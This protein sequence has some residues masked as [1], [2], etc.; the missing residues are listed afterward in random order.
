MVTAGTAMDRTSG[1]LPWVNRPA[2]C[3]GKKKITAENTRER[4]A[5]AAKQRFS[6]AV[7]LP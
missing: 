1:S 2:A 6:M 3:S 5:L 4:M 7:T